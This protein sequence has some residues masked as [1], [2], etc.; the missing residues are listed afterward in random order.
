MSPAPEGDNT[1]QMHALS[2]RRFSNVA[3]WVWQKSVTRRRGDAE[4][5][6][7]LS[8]PC[9]PRRHRCGAESAGRF[10]ADGRGNLEET[11][12][13]EQVEQTDDSRDKNAEH[14]TMVPESA[15]SEDDEGRNEPVQ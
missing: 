11:A 9:S 4:E 10:A 6:G 5:G 13:L 3:K 12:A 2:N 1:F 15:D 8:S 14:E 7:S